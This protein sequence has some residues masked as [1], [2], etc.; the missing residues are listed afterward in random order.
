M[1]IIGKQDYCCQLRKKENINKTTKLFN[2][3]GARGRQTVTSIQLPWQQDLYLYSSIIKN[4][5][6]LTLKLSLTVKLSLR[7]SSVEQGLIATRLSV[8]EALVIKVD[9]NIHSWTS[10]QLKIFIPGC[11]ITCVQST[12][13]RILCTPVQSNIP[14]H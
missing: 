7:Q 8:L 5:S 1:F 11:S 3:F 6:Y 4:T 9:E 10:K 12:V 2:S 14:L 13:Y